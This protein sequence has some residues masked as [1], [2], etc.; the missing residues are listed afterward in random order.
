MD[1]SPEETLNSVSSK[2]PNE[3]LKLERFPIDD[4][5]SSESETTQ[6]QHPT[7]IT[8]VKERET[9]D[10]HIDF[11]FSLLGLIVGIGNVWRYYVSFISSNYYI[12]LHCQ[13]PL[14]M[15]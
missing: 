10:S 7:I 4:L 3:S 12:E 1:C 14:S 11:V 5:K 8:P 13:I 6:Q 9:W 2:S 15:L